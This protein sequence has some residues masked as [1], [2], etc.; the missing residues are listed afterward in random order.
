[1]STTELGPPQY[2]RCEYLLNPLGIEDARPRLSW[3]VRDPRKGAVQSA[4]RIL[5]AST[6]ELLEGDGADVWD[7]GKVVTD[8]SVH[9]PYGGPALSSRQRVYWKVRTWDGGD[10]ASPWS[11]TA[12]WE[13]GLL[14]RDEW[15]G[16]WISVAPRDGERGEPCPFLRRRFATSKEVARARV[17]VT[18]R[19]LYELH[20]NGDRIG[21]DYFTPG[22]TD[23]NVRIP[24]QVYDVTDALRE[25]DNVLAAV[26]GD[27]WAC[28]Y[29]VWENNRSIWATQPS[30]LAQLVVDYADGTAETVVTDANWRT[31]T[32]PIPQSDIYNGETYDAR[33]EMPGWDRPDFDDA[34]WDHAQIVKPTSALLTAKPCTNVRAI[35]ELKPTEMTEPSPGTYIFNLAQNIVGWVRL[36]VRAEAGTTI[37]LRF[38][39]MLNDDG[40]VYTENLRAA[41]ATDEYICKGADDEVYEPRFTFHGFQYVEL[42][43]CPY[44]P[45]MDAITGV[46]LH[47][48]TPP[49]GV[50]ECSNE[51]VN[52][53]QSN[54]RWGQKGN[55]L[56]VPTDC[57]QRNERLGWLGDAQ[58]F[59]RTACFNS[60][61]AHRE[62]I[63]REFLS[64]V[65]ADPIVT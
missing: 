47:S 63:F 13:M 16:S 38:A 39:E 61:S 4:Y 53:L 2:L 56:E 45:E 19:G 27:G 10:T 29:L 57:P 26:L 35:E 20:L 58:V 1:M 3:E 40:T 59:V 37:T 28:G 11:E 6:P 8:Q 54:I 51:M 62:S 25:G 55:F 50:F 17:Y 24:Y 31:T 9:V 43:G 12:Y 49:T 14:D 52:K 48:D 23:Y 60:L 15:T 34:D 36:R 18:A 65:T 33:L 64:V 21:Q 30:L 22:W 41:K 46:V 44:R 5:A 32:G 7:S 42:T